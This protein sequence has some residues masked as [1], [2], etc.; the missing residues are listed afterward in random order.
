MDTELAEQRIPLE[1]VYGIHYLEIDFANPPERGARFVVEPAKSFRCPAPQGGV[2]GIAVAVEILTDG[3]LAPT[4][5]VEPNDRRPPFS[6]IGNLVIQRKP[7][8]PTVR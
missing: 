7:A 1:V 6:G 8:T 4:F 3:F 2:N 5:K